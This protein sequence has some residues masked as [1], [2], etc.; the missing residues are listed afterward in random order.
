MSYWTIGQYDMDRKSIA[1]S[2][3]LLL[4]ISTQSLTS[5][6]ALYVHNINF[7]SLNYLSWKHFSLLLVENAKN[8]H[9]H[10]LLV[11]LFELMKSNSFN[12]N[13]LP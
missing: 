6:T 10:I 7:N 1:N 12:Q 3:L 13:N 8:P 9:T 2:K 4:N 5:I 11:G